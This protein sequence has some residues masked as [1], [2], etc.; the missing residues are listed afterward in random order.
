MLYLTDKKR[1]LICHP[2]SISNLHKMAI[3]LGIHPCWFHK[4]HYDIPKKRVAEIEAKCYI[5]TPKIIV[6]L[7]KQQNEKDI[8]NTISCS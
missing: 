8:C 2:Y 6:K 5:V 3:E 7:I 1:H 4:T